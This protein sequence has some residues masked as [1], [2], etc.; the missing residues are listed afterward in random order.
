MRVG[1]NHNR[2]KQK[3]ANKRQTVAERFTLIII[4][5]NTPA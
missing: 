3:K 2:A 5:Y 1:G 4:F